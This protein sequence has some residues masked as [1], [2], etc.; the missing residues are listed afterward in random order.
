MRRLVLLLSLVLLSASAAHGQP[1]TRSFSLTDGSGPTAVTLDWSFFAATSRAESGFPSSF[2]MVIDTKSEAVSVA[3]VG[4]ALDRLLGRLSAREPLPESF[5]VLFGAVREPLEAELQRRL[6]LSGANW[7]LSTGKPRKGAY[8]AVVKD[9]LASIIGRSAIAAA[10]RRHGYALRLDNV[11]TI[12]QDP[13][14][15]RS[16]G[17]VPTHVGVME[18]SAHKVTN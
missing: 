15:P 18:M 13:P 17:W 7:N 6:R 12:T 9:E 14:E 10:F 5:Y 1:A 4:Q 8:Y 11:A 16:L 2:S 3:S